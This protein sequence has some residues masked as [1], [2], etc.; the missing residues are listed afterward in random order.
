MTEAKKPKGFRKYAEPQP[1][2]PDPAAKGYKKYLKTAKEIDEAVFRDGSEDLLHVPKET[3]DKLHRDGIDLMWASTMCMGAPQDRN[4]AEKRANGWEFVEEG[5]FDKELVPR[6]QVDNLRLM[7]RD[8]RLSDKQARQQ[9]ADAEAPPTVLRQRA[10]E[11]DLRG[12]T[13]DARHSS[14]RG[15]NKIRSTLE[16]VQVGPIGDE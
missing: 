16:R 3:M 2:K 12:V 13:L 10:G 5:D 9:L 7:A 11:G 4:I 8:K 14:A 1:S 6:I 15:Y